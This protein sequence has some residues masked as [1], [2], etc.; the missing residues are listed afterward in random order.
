MCSPTSAGRNY[1]TTSASIRSSASGTGRHSSRC[2]SRKK[3]T[4]RLYI[5]ACDSQMQEKMFRDALD[6]AGF[7]KSRLVSLDIRNRTTE[8]AVEAIKGMI[9]QAPDRL[10]P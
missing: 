10:R 3:N 4:D 2:F 8:E 9:V 7:D 6:A 1:S 5:A